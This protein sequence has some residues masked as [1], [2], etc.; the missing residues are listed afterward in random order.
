[1]TLGGI[2]CA[3]PP[4]VLAS[5]YGNK[6]ITGSIIHFFWII[7]LIEIVGL[8]SFV[9]G[10][11]RSFS[12]RTSDAIT[13]K[14]RLDKP[15][16][17]LLV[18]GQMNWVDGPGLSSILFFIV[19]VQNLYYSY[20]RWNKPGYLEDP[21]FFTQFLL[22]ILPLTWVIWK[23]VRPKAP[24]HAILLGVSYKPKDEREATIVSKA[25]LYSMGIN[26][27]IIFLLFLILLNAPRPTT[28]SLAQLFFGIIFLQRALFQMI[29][30]R[31]GLGRK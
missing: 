7:P 28:Y 18:G 5:I 4:I 20:D 30:W 17:E 25:G 9:T 23:I 27:I 12:Q 26:V 16:S 15:V 19:A 13:E 22:I 21:Q 1:M 2:I 29:A 10:L 3:L 6:E 14:L 24:W 11:R 8:F 31:M